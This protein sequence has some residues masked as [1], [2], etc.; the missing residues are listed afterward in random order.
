[1]PNAV[2]IY[3]EAATNHDFLGIGQPIC[4]HFCSYIMYIICNQ[5]WEKP[6]TRNEYVHFKLIFKTKTN[7]N[8]KFMHKQVT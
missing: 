4:I 7:F 8:M 5:L 6:L 2:D 1:M 3:R